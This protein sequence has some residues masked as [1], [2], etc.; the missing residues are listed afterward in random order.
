[1]TPALGN[2]TG[3][4]ASR[5]TAGQQGGQLA[6]KKPGSETNK[7]PEANTGLQEL[8]RAAELIPG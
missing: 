8:M 1:M 7:T 6:R 2:L 3:E 4:S 5:A